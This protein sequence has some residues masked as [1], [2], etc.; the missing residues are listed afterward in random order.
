[1]AAPYLKDKNVIPSGSEERTNQDEPVARYKHAAVAVEQCMLVWGGQN[2]ITPI[3]TSTVESFNLLSMTWEE[4]QQLRGQAFPENLS[5]MAVTY[6]EESVYWFGGLTGTYP[7]QRLYSS[8]L[9]QIDLASLVCKPLVPAKGSV[10]PTP[11]ANSHMVLQKR[12]LVLYGGVHGDHV[13][14]DL[15]TFDLDKSKLEILVY[16][17]KVVQYKGLFWFLSYTVC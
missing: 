4:P 9:H 1:M 2:R 12:N 14:D 10:C 3:Q 8:T 6:D 11:R 15:H 13:M 7:S 16:Y 5:R 17:T